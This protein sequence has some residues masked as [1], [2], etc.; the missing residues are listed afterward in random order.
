MVKAHQIV[1]ILDE[2]PS[3][4]NDLNPFPPHTAEEL[5][6]SPP[7]AYR[8]QTRQ[9]PYLDVFLGHLTTGI[10]IDSGATGNMIRQS[11]A[12]LLGAK[13]T[14]SSQSVHQADG[15][16]TL[17]VT[18]ETRV[19]LSRDKHLFYFEGLVVQDLD[20]E[21]LAGTPFIELNDIAIRPAK[22]EV[23]LGDGSSY[24][25]GS[26]C[27]QQPNATARYA[28]LLRATP[29][30]QTIWPG[31]YLEVELLDDAPSDCEY[32]LQPHI[33]TAGPKRP[34]WPDPSIV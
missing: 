17:K 29:S 27:Y 14:P 11:T 12:N 2:E 32:A 25:Y 7:I 9:S 22:R 21:L 24:T 15:S 28:F 10:T 8:I 31:E 13:V 5:A 30:T 4:D 3:Y 18:G 19:S 26:F 6:N 20:V 34:I 16:S 23:I 33:V 1:D